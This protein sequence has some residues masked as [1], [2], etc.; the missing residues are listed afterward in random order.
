MHA[1]EGHTDFVRSLAFS[2]DGTR[3][4]TGSW[5]NTARVW[6]VAGGK[7]VAILDHR[8]G[9]VAT[10]SIAPDG[11]RIVTAGGDGTAKLWERAPAGSTPCSRRTSRASAS[12]S[13][14]PTA[15]RC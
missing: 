10:V 1:L 12:R 6:D 7:L 3:L 14:H 11:K 15:R 2:A 5:D 8:S 13:F 9:M 4:V